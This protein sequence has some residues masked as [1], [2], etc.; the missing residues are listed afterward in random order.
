M[1]CSDSTKEIF[2][3]KLTL[4]RLVNNFSAYYRTRMLI[5]TFTRARHWSLSWAR[6]IQFTPSHP[7]S[8]RSIL[9]LSSHLRLGLPSGLFLSCF[10]TKILYAFHTSSLWNFIQ[11]PVTS[12]LLGPNILLNTLFSNILSLC[13]SLN[14]TDQ[15]PH[16]YKTKGEII[17]LYT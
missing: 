1:F 6:W 4:A 2:H 11:P 14:V 7:I 12:S 5:T 10:P 13:S 8:L 17:F 9:L 15:V 16:P 3:E